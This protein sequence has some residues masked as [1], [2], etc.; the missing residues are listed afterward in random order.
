[1]AARVPR[2]PDA[3]DRGIRRRA[4][5]GRGTADR[6][7]R[8][9]AGRCR[10]ERPGARGG[11]HHGA[12]RAGR[13]EQRRDDPRRRGLR[14]CRRGDDRR[15]RHRR[16]GRRDGSGARGR[17]RVRPAGDRPRGGGAS[18]H[19]AAGGAAR[20]PDA[21]GG[22]LRS[23]RPAVQAGDGGGGHQRRRR[24]TRTSSM[25]PRPAPWARCTTPSGTPLPA[26]VE[27][28]A[29]AVRAAEDG[30]RA[31]DQAIQAARAELSRASGGASP[32]EIREADNA[33]SSA[34]RQLATAQAQIP[35]DPN[36]IADLQDAVGL[37]ILRREQLSRPPDTSAAAGGTGLRALP[38][39]RGGRGDSTKAREEAS[40][41]P[42]GERGAV[43]HQLPRRVDN[44]TVKRGADPLRRGDDGSGRGR[45]GHRFRGRGRREPARGRRRGD[46]RAPRRHAAPRGRGEDRPPGTSSGEGGEAPLVT[47]V[48]HAA[49]RPA[50]ARADRRA[51]GAERPV[52]IPVGATGARCS[53]SRSRPSP[54][55]RAASP[56]SRSSWRP[57]ATGR[58]PRRDS[59]SSRP[60]SPPTGSSRSPP[61]TTSSLRAT[62]SWSVNDGRR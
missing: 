28:S 54:P 7:L 58:T 4:E 26:P 18:R 29:D 31:A 39:R 48:A 41:L 6:P 33:I 23:R 16:R 10:G 56:A 25:R 43:P 53:R 34:Q 1:M 32:V 8:R 49:A 19:R 21:A 47:V 14:G 36:E 50:D 17:R 2:Q 38:A 57:E 3:V 27:G 22:G 46:V 11:A 45:A 15:R 5:P 62:W 40:V 37:A 9:V 24:R 59:W 52:T 35:A 12:G 42:P 60:V 55:V 13:A 51:A 61:S 30:V 44:V 20:L